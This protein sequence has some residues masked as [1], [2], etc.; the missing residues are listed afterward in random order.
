METLKF[1]G[2]L[3]AHAMPFNTD[4]SIDYQTLSEDV[5]YLCGSGCI[6]GVVTNAHAAECDLL[7]FEER[8]RVLKTVLSVTKGSFPVIAGVG[9]DSTYEMVKMAQEAEK[10]GASAVLVFP[11]N[12]WIAG[13]PH[14]AP[15]HYYKALSEG[16]N[17]PIIAYQYPVWRGKACYSPEQLLDIAGIEKVIAIKDAIWDYCIFEEECAFLREK[18]PHI[19]ILSANDEFLLPSYMV[20]ADATLVSYGALAP[21]EIYQML[22]YAKEEKYRQAKEI[23]DRM[24]P[25]TKSIYSAAARS[26][27]RARSKEAL[28]LMGRFKNSVVRPPLLPLTGE[29]RKEM[30]AAVKQSGLN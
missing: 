12:S 17:I 8:I 5:K 26:S 20:A 15:F 13:K 2:V 22:N 18:A 6:E 24:I 23:Y 7:T 21:Y 27:M 11:P 30:A 3:A 1:T 9:A 16:I 25:F 28:V 14:K 4:Y 29:E 10:N 19:Q